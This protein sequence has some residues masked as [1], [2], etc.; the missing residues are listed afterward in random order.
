MLLLV[1]FMALLAVSVLFLFVYAPDPL[2]APYPSVEDLRG[3]LD[4]LLKTFNLFN[5]L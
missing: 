4:W 3:V 5:Y 1:G 2:K